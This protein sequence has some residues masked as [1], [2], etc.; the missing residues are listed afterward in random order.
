MKLASRCIPTELLPYENEEA[1]TRMMVKLFEKTPSLAILP[2]VSTDDNLTRRT[3]GGIPGVKLKDK[4][5]V[6]KV[7]TNS[8]KNGIT[9]L[10]KAYNSPDLKNLEHFAIESPFLDKYLQ[11]IKRCNCANAFVSLLGPFT[12]SQMLNQAAEEQF[13][14]DKTYRKLFIQAVCVKALWIIEKIKEVNP[15]TV[16]VIILEEPLLANLGDLKRENEEITNDLVINLFAKVVEKLKEAGAYVGVQCM[17]KC[18]W[19]IPMAAGVDLISFDAYNNPNNLCIMPEQIIEFVARGGKINW[20]IVPT[21][22]ETIVKDMNLDY[23]TNRLVA[24]M[25]G[26]IVAGVPAKFVYNSA[27]V[28]IQG[29]VEKLPLIFAEKAVILSTQLAKRIPVVKED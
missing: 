20:A 17:G 2:A 11:M 9:K 28:S 22:N 10:D 1:V 3:L 18:D 15:S 7:D 16:P 21:T 24:T 26:L 23:L 27:V 12:V 19:K 29:T 14:I 8:Y 13:L 5:L 25:E 6:L 4:K